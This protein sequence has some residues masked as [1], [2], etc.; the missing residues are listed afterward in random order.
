MAY[1][2]LVHEPGQPGIVFSAMVGDLVARGWAIASQAFALAVLVQGAAPPVTPLNGAAG[3]GGVMIGQAFRRSDGPSVALAAADLAGLVDQDPEDVCAR[4]IEEAWGGYVAVLARDRRVPPTVLR[5]PTGFV[6]AFLWSRD[7][8]TLI[9]STIPEGLAAPSDLALDWERIADVLA[10]PARSGGAP[11]LVGIVDVG[12]GSCRWGAQGRQ[13]RT[14]WSPAKFAGGRRQWPSRA[15]LRSCVDATIAT[16]ANGADKIVCEISGGLDSAIVATGLTAVGRRADRAIN[17]YRDQAEADERVY[18]Q[19]AAERA[20]V[21]LETVRRDPFAL[22]A[23]AFARSAASVRPNFN[24]LDPGYDAALTQALE[25]AGADVLFTGHGGDVVFLQVGAASLASDL[26]SG[27][28]CEGSRAR[29]LAEVARRTRRSV[30]S[31]GLEALQRRPG[32]LSPES[33]VAPSGIFKRAKPE[34]K[35]PWMVEA[36]RHTAAKQAQILG[37]VTSLTL[38]GATGR[39][40]RARLAHPL[41]SQPVIE[42]CLAI[43]ATVL[44]AGETERSFAREAF[45]DRLPASIIERRSKGDISVFFGRSLAASIGF[46]RPFLLDGRL[47]AEGLI[48]RERLDAALTVDAMVW[49]DATVEI[50]AAATLE[51][52]IGHWEGRIAAAR[53]QGAEGRAP[54]T[55][56]GPPKASSRKAK[57][58]R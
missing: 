34:R 40:E 43:P 11:P 6:E 52:W 14:L 22:D 49:K 46:L 36:T 58:R 45:A 48:D 39:A 9:G 15:D 18:A 12:P 38:N 27:A 51:A 5:D 17:F 16:L 1:L 35:H 33:L 24:A 25:Q 10:D 41:L 19:A 47:A 21:P 3:L 20:G 4:L 7:G 31:L 55:V 57:A 44:S 29:R 2:V 13:S 54:A 23:Q 42:L 30:W 53:R 37:L 8:V 26:L 50:L 28:P 32:R 56:S